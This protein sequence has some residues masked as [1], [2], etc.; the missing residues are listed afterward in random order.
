MSTIVSQEEL[1]SVELAYLVTVK[2]AAETL[3]PMVSLVLFARFL[4]LFCQI[5]VLFAGFLVLFARLL[6]LFARFLVLLAR[7]S[8]FVFSLWSNLSF[9]RK[10]SIKVGFVCW[11]WRFVCWQ[12]PVFKNFGHPQNWY[13]CVL[14]QFTSVPVTYDQQHQTLSQQGARVL[15]LGIRSL[16][17][18][19]SSQQV[20][21]V[22]CVCNPGLW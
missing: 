8:P 7:F 1:G 2:G 4:V 13:V 19:L 20:R 5:F 21:R 22:A 16:G 18:G 11:Q 15:A 3:K 12:R 9:L 10:R 17:K 14:L 6:V